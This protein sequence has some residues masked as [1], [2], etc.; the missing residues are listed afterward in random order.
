MY[1]S[2]LG[3]KYILVGIIFLMNP[4]I[5]VIDVLP[6]FIGYFFILKALWPVSVMY[7]HFRDASDSF[8]RLAFVSIVKTVIFPVIFI[9]APSEITWL[10]LLSFVFAVIEIFYSLVAFSKL[11]EGIYYSAERGAG[12]KLFDGYDNSR[13]FTVI[14]VCFKPIAA[15]IPELTSLS[16]GGYGT[17]TENGIPDHLGLR[18]PLMI[19]MLV[20]SLAVAI[21]WYVTTRR[22]FKNVLSDSEYISSLYEKHKVFEVKNPHIIDRRITLSALAIFTAGAF[23]AIE[24][25]LDGINYIPNFIAGGFFIAAFIRLRKIFPKMARTGILTSLI[26]SVISAAGWGFSIFFTSSYIIS[27]SNEIGMAVGYGQQVAAYLAANEKITMHFITMCTIFAIEA[28]IF[29]VLLVIIAKTLKACLMRHGGRPIYELG[30][31]HDKNVLL[32]S[33]RAERV[34]IAFAVALGIVS[35]GLSVVQMV[36]VATD[37]SLWVIDIGVRIAWACLFASACDKIKESSKEKYIFVNTEITGEK[38]SV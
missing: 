10:L 25:K 36:L 8:R 31:M 26:Y 35:A 1:G 16:G 2:D 6:D 33:T 30:Q 7:P 5:S 12:K 19:V 21:A 20:I 34:R 22:Y 24:L 23:F 3:L 27:N 32:R 4:N 37:Y 15:F 38:G 11:Y 28:L 14:Y 18:I 9:V 29:S 17:V 13:L